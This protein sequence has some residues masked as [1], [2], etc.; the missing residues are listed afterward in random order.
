MYI[1]SQK[2]SRFDE[3][4]H[5]LYDT[6]FLKHFH[7]KK[8]ICIF[9]YVPKYIFNFFTLFHSLIH[10]QTRPPVSLKRNVIKILRDNFSDFFFF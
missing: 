7:A 8:I 3:L 2:E 1:C 6:L 10:A 9:L 5:I 4:Q